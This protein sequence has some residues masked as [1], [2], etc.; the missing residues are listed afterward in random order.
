MVLSFGRRGRYWFCRL[1]SCSD[2]RRG[3]LDGGRLLY[4]SLLCGREDGVQCGAFHARHEFDDAVVAD[5][6]DQAI[7]DLIA[8]VA[9]RHLAA[10]EA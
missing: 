7:D 6:E 5:V 1:W 10:L 3:L 9:V 2:W 4:L 8:E